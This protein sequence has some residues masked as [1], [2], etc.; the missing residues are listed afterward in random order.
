MTDFIITNKKI[1]TTQFLDA[2][3]CSEYK[4][5]LAKI[6]IKIILKHHRKIFTDEKFIVELW[7]NDSNTETYRRRLLENIRL[8]RTNDFVVI[9]ESW[10][11]RKNN[12]EEVATEA[13]G[14][15]LV[16]LNTGNNKEIPWFR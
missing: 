1:H 13:L 9:N 3:A 15:P 10:D 2:D 14:K 16:T 5:V 12:I 8:K 4:L 7:L 11:K 6:Q